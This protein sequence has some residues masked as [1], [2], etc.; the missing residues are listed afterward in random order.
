MAIMVFIRPGPSANGDKCRRENEKQ[1][2]NT[3]QQGI[4][5][6]AHHAGEDTDGAADNKSNADDGEAR[7]PGVADAEQDAR[8][9]VAP[10]FIGAEEVLK[11]R[12]QIGIGHPK[13]RIKRCQKWPE[14]RND[15]DQ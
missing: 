1:F 15:G 11:A 13:H 5:P 7:K 9:Q 12:R 4:D 6:T 3:L 10:D 2:D 14:N 8:E